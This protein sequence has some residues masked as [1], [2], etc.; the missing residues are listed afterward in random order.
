MLK[1]KWLSSILFA[2]ILSITMLGG[3][4]TKTLAAENLNFEENDTDLVTVYQKNEIKDLKQLFNRAK[5]N[6]NDINLKFDKS[7]NSLIPDTSTDKSVGITTKS[8]ISNSIIKKT[9]STEQ[10]LNVRKNKE[11]EINTYA[12]TVFTQFT[13]TDKNIK[14]VTISPNYIGD[15]SDSKPD[16]SYGVVAWGTIY[17]DKIYDVGSNYH[18]FLAIKTIKGGW[19][20]EDSTETLSYQHAIAIE[21]GFNENRILKYATSD[22]YTDG[23]TFYKDVSMPYIDTD[24][25]LVAYG[26]QTSVLIRR[27]TSSWSFPFSMGYSTIADIP[28]GTH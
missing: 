6:I 16:G 13:V 15:I 4:N 11:I 26:M 21:E 14:D 27:G 24:E 8:S 7:S 9:Y 20:V 23:S 17:F 3:I 5:N 18:T 10:L 2:G 22:V 28:L 25:S 12:K 19:N 1:L